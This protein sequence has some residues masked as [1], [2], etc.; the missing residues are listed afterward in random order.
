MYSQPTYLTV[1]Y[2]LIHVFAMIV[3]WVERLSIVRYDY[4]DV[5]RL[6]CCGLHGSDIYLYESLRAFGVCVVDDVV[7]TLKK[8][9]LTT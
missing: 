7:L 1:V 2:D 9:L 6:C 8:K 5:A 4:C 3:Q